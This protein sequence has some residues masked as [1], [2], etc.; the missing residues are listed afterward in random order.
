MVQHEKKTNVKSPADDLEPYRRLVELQKQMIELVRQHEK[1]KSECAALRKQ[2]LDEMTR[3]RSRWNLRRIINRP[4]VGWVK[5]LAEV[6]KPRLESRP[7][8]NGSFLP[9]C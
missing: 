5:R 1:T 9:S 7:Q 2:L 8:P 4:A 3:R 6:W